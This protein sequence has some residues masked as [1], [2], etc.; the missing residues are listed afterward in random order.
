[1]GVLPCGAH[2]WGDLVHRGAQPS[3]RDPAASPADLAVTVRLV[4]AGRTVDVKLVDHL[5]IGDQGRFVSIRRNHPECF[6]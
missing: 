6:G 5:I 3:P 4:A 1:M 2:R